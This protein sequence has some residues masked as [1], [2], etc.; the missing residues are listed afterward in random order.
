MIRRVAPATRNLRRKLLNE[1]RKHADRVLVPDR[2]A[3]RQPP[4]GLSDIRH[5]A[6]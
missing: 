4:S 1:S 5:L 6:G 2:L 3:V